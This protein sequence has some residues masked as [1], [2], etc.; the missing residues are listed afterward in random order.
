MKTT[1]YVFLMISIMLGCNPS[2]ENNTEGF[3]VEARTQDYSE[4]LTQDILD[5]S[6][7]QQDLE[8]VSVDAVEELTPEIDLTADGKE[9][10]PLDENSEDIVTCEDDD[11]CSVD[12]FDPELDQCVNM[13]DEN[14]HECSNDLACNLEDICSC[15]EGELHCVI[16]KN[17]CTDGICKKEETKKECTFGCDVEFSVCNECIE[18]N[19]CIEDDSYPCEE[20]VCPNH[21]CALKPLPSGSLCG[22]SGN[23][24]CQGVDCVNIC[25]DGNP[26]TTDIWLSQ[27]S[28]C[29][30]GFEYGCDHCLIDA[31]CINE[32]TMCNCPPEEDQFICYESLPECD[33]GVCQ[34]NEV[35][36]EE[37]LFGCHEFSGECKQEGE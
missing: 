30:N 27:D 21:H 13:A 10:T 4:E 11:P 2:E 8:E 1:L 16:F 35:V 9:D 37:C 14:C 32:I 25:D 5:V 7:E 20:F 34:T 6:T 3:D 19:D 31:D 26:C 33:N 18:A 29:A 36:I 23:W 17:K 22:D 12:Y 15:H 28:S 24:Q